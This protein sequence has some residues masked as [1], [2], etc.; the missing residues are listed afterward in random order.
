MKIIYVEKVTDNTQIV[1]SL[2]T[3]LFPPC[4]NPAFHFIIRNHTLLPRIFEPSLDHPFEREFAN[5]LVV[6]CIIR[7]R[8]NDLSFSLLS[9]T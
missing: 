2:K 3:I 7:L 4:S 5:D 1:Y 9:L 6:A 8:L